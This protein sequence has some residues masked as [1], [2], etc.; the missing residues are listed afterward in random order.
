V[1]TEL[2]AAFGFSFDTA[3]LNERKCSVGE[4]REPAPTVAS[5][6]GLYRLAANVNH[7]CEQNLLWTHPP[8]SSGF[9][10]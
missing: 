6:S 9:A 8:E 2:L 5:G 10:A 4:A 1:F 7:S 3:A